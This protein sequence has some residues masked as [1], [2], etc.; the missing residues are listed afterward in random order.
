[1]TL[2]QDITSIKQ[3]YREWFGIARHELEQLMLQQ[4]QSFHCSTCEASGQAPPADVTQPLHEDCGFRLWQEAVITLLA[5]DVG[6]KICAT[7]AMIQS[8]RDIKG[9]CHMCGVCCKLASSEFDFDSLKAKAAQGDSFASQFTSI[10]IPYETVEEVQALFPELVTDMLEQTEGPVYFYHCPY[11]DEQ[12]RCSIY[13]DP[14]RPDICAE[15][16]Q[17]PLTLMYKNCGYQPWKNEMM[18]S[19]LMA[20]ATLELCTYFIDKIQQAQ[21][22]TLPSH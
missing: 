11:L 20:H 21:S 2:T 18:P 6:Q 19:M 10:F 17:T 7:L 5:Q 1:M 13:N 16:P 9:K 8:Q 14:K 4:R 22:T 15:Y 12:N 3:Q